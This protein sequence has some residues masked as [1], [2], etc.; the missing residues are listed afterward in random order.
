MISEM[1]GF[2]EDISDPINGEL[3]D[4]Q[5]TAKLLERYLSAGIDRINQIASMDEE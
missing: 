2:K 5:A 4:Y 1:V 3:G